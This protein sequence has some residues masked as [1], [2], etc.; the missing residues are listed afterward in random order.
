M[1][2]DYRS[3]YQRYRR[4]YTYLGPIVKSPIF[5]AYFSVVMSIFTVA[6]FVA[7]AIRPTLATIIGLQKQIEDKQDFNRRLDEKINALSQLQIDY[8]A[9]ERDLPLVFTA[10]PQDPAVSEAVILL[11]K[12]ATAAGVTLTNISIP[13]ADYSRPLPASGAAVASVSSQT[14]E[15]SVKISGGFDNLKNFF[16]LLGNLPRLFSPAKTVVSQEAAKAGLES[17]ASVNIYFLP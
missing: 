8:Q 10:L 4:Y 3:E 11:E 13:K 15:V 2:L 16:E 9:V 5:R 1:A 17:Q 7:F 12:T 6:I 14:V